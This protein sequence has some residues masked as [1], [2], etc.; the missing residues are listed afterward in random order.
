[1][2]KSRGDAAVQASFAVLPDLPHVPPVYSRYNL[3]PKV[4][5]ARGDGPQA[6]QSFKDE[7]DVNVIMRRAMA[8]GQLIDPVQLARATRIARY[9]DASFMPESFLDAQLYV[10]EAGEAFMKLPAAIRKRFDNNVAALLEFLG[11]EANRPEAEKLGL[12][13]AKQGG[14]GGAPD[15]EAKA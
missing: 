3:P 5:L 9:E 10:Q 12:G 8:S 13:N 1:M 6:D 11:N 2:T 7:C 15:G 4:R 14:A